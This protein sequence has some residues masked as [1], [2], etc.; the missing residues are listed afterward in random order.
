MHLVRR[1]STA[2]EIAAPTDDVDRRPTNAKSRA[3]PRRSLIKARARLIQT[4]L[5][6][7]RVDPAT[8]EQVIRH[9]VEWSGQ[10]TGRAVYAC[11]VHM[12]TEAAWTPD[13][14]AVLRD[15]DLVVPD[16]MPLVWLFRVM[17]TSDVE[18]VRGPQLMLDACDQCAAR[19]I[20]IG[21]VGSTAAVMERLRAELAARFPGLR[22]ACAITPPVTADATGC[23]PVL[24]AIGESGARVVF[25]ALG[26]P[27][28]EQW[29]HSVK[30][31]TSAVLIGVGAA[32]DFIA[33]TKPQAPAF[34]QKV[35]CEWLFRLATEP[36]RL[37]RRYL[38]SNA[39][40]ALLIARHLW[41]RPGS[42]VQ[43]Q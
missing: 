30:E 23:Q 9:I 17:G 22:I 40:F 7:I 33:G 27:K 5:L 24:R 39:R 38:I 32:F 37:W 10:S 18:R 15:A 4:K 12:L 11:N 41:A 34:V 6:S 28:Q 3:E 8:R 2:R 29:I 20:P 25:I 19:S 35:G 36:R 1:T 31:E 42:I 21:L 13:F 14:A 43:R 16:G 26:C